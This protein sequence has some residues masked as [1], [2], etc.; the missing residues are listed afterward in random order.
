MHTKNITRRS[1][2]VGAGAS[3][4]VLAGIGNAAESE[5]KWIIPHSSGNKPPR[6]KAPENAC[7]C[8]MH[9]YDKR[10]PA[11]PHWKSRPTEANVSDYRKF[12]NKIGTSRTVVVTPSTYGVDNRCTVDAVLQFGKSAR[13]I[14]V[15]DTSITDK[16]LEIL[17]NAGICGI[18]VNFVS[19]QSWGVT[20]LA[21]LKT[22][23]ARVKNFD[24][25][26]QILMSGDQIASAKD[27]LNT[28][29]VPVVID[30]IGRIPQPAGIEHPAYKAILQLLDRGNT[31]VKLSG[32]YMDTK[33]GHPNYDDIE[34][35]ARGF[36]KIAPD[37]MVWGSDWPHPT[38]KEKPNDAI[39]F[40]LISQWASDHSVIEKILVKNPEVLY[41]F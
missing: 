17:A 38:E 18:R 2:V 26:V 40:D 12:Q 36:I 29:P 22:L 4:A 39:L 6:Y 21:M 5:E 8:H 24:W 11:S 33:I 7:D 32:A 16:E 13:G 19:P 31:W 1:F 14:A 23:S 15:V 10:F 3:L 41:K 28:L 30:H 25:H 9:I 37:R 34:E 27:V 20:T 35:I